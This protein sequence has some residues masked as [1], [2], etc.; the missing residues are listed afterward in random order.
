MSSP[1]KIVCAFNIP[2]ASS[3]DGQ[4]EQA[5]H[6]AHGLIEA[7]LEFALGGV[8]FAPPLMNHANVVMGH[9]VLGREGNG[10]F[11]MI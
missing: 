7:T 9:Q 6:F 5:T 2:F 8:R 10:L 3:N 1:D 4:M 11:E